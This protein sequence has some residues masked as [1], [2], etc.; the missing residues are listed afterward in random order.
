MPAGG[1]ARRRREL[2]Q[3]DLIDG[4]AVDRLVD[5][6][7]VGAGDLVLDIGAGRGPISDALL[8]RGARVVA[9]E[10]DRARVAA[11][12]HR[13]A[14]EPRARV[15]GGDALRVRLPSRPFA[16]V[17][18]PPFGITTPLLRRLLGRPWGPLV[19]VDVVLQ[20]QAAR[21]L[22]NPTGPAALAWSPWWE[23][24]LGPRFAR[25]CFR[26]VPPCDA[27]VL[28]VRRRPQPLLPAELAPP[29]AGFVAQHHRRWA[30][31]DRGARWWAR[32]F[33]NRF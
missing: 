6:A 26:P 29:F 9:I 1:P 13:Y 27:C 32:R 31:P 5:V 7:A 22:A 19:Q 21:R 12:A 10:L 24:E 23:L 4:R 3:H 8:A 20:R 17:A 11:L 2:G 28:S 30:G 14:T 25:S 33:R 16:V 15:V 18:N